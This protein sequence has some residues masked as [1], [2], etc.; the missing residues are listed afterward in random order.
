MNKKRYLKNFVGGGVE[1]KLHLVLS[2]GYFMIAKK[3]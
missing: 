3:K 1:D 2:A